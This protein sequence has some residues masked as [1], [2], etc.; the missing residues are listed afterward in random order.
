MRRVG[1]NDPVRVNEIEIIPSTNLI[2][3]WNFHAAK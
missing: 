3:I 2:K 1:R